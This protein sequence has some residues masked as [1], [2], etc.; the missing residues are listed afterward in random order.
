MKCVRQA[1]C[2]I[3]DNSI[4]H[5]S[6]VMHR[7]TRLEIPCNF[8]NVSRFY[9]HMICAMSWICLLIKIGTGGLL[10]RG[11]NNQIAALTSNGMLS[12]CVVHNGQ[13]IKTVYC[14][15]SFVSAG[16]KL[17]DLSS[18]NND[19]MS[20]ALFDVFPTLLRESYCSTACSNDTLS[21]LFGHPLC[22]KLRNQK[23][24]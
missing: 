14:H 9:G 11:F 13:F 10:F 19:T 6:W 16:K 1:V 22:S 8:Q 20:I 2:S 15:I 7:L 17:A 18:N 3:L 23:W 21:P 12:H 4:E 24:V 5:N